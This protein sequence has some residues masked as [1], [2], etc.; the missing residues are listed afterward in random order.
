MS[1]AKHQ[2]DT[3]Q[4]EFAFLKTSTKDLSKQNIFLNI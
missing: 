3:K 4:Y 1:L 2:Q